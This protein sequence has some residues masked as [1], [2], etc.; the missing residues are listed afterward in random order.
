MAIAYKRE[1]SVRSA[2]VS[3]HSPVSERF[4]L[5]S[6]QSVFS[7]PVSYHKLS[8]FQ[9]LPSSSHSLFDTQLHCVIMPTLHPRGLKR[10]AS[11]ENNHDVTPSRPPSKKL[12]HVPASD[13]L[14]ATSD[15]RAIDETPSK[16]ARWSNCATGTP[17]ERLD[18][19]ESAVALLQYHRTVQQ[20]LEEAEANQGELQ[21]KII[22][23]FGDFALDDLLAY[24]PDRL[25]MLQALIANKELQ[26]Q[27]LASELAHQRD[28][29]GMEL[30]RSCEADLE[31]VRIEVEKLR[32]EE[33]D[34]KHRVDAIVNSI[35]PY[36]QYH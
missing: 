29:L 28:T 20:N 8:H 24:P 32:A 1:S 2:L 26:I 3:C 34:L 33:G 31:L 25:D 10:E 30:Q 11:I 35:E 36:A 9:T 22:D 17:M 16:A 19:K 14:E 5:L 6:L 21:S 15:D 23:I 18:I 4:L 7:L 12:Q 27:E 13:E